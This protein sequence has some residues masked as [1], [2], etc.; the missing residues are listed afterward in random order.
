MK[1]KLT[2]LTFIIVILI[3][4]GCSNA[5]EPVSASNKISNIAQLP[6]GVSEWN[7]NGYPAGGMGVLGLFNL[8]VDSSQATAELSSLRTNEL[9]DV[10]ESVDITNFLM[11]APCTNCAKIKSVSLDVDGN[12]VVSIGI[13]HPFDV[14]EPLKPVSGRNRADRHVFNVEGIIVSNAP[15]TSFPLIGEAV[16]DFSLLNA[17]GYTDYLDPSLDEIYP[18]DATI[19]PYVLHFDDYSAGNFD[20][21]YP[22]GFQSVTDP[23]PSGNLVMAMGCDYNYQDYV[24]ALDGKMDFIYA[25]GCTYAVSAASKNDRFHPEY[26]I[27]QHNKKAASEVRFEIISND[28][29]GGDTSSS[30]QIEVH[31][32]DINHGVAVGDALNEMR[33]DSSVN[34]IF[35]DVPGIITSPVVIDGSTPISGTGHDPSDPLIYQGTI[36]N[37]NGAPEGEYPG[38]IKVTDNYAPG[39]NES[40]LLNTLDGI[41]RVAPTENP[42]AGLF[43]ID[44]FATYQTFSISVASGNEEPVAILLSDPDPAQISQFDTVDFDATTSYD[45][46]GSITEYAFD[47]DWTGYPDPLSFAPDE[48]NTTGLATSTPYANAGTFIAGLRVTD[49]LGAVGYDSVTVEVSEIQVIYVDDSN[50]SGTENGTMQYPYNTIQEGLNAASN[51]FEVWVDDSGVN[52]TGPVTLKSGVVLKSVN[53]NSGD[54]DDEACIAYE[55]T[56]AVVIGTDNATIQGFVIDG[57]RYGIDCDGSSPEIIDCRVVNLRYADCIGIWLRSG[58]H[59]HLDGIEVYDLNNNTDYGYATFYGIV[60]DNCPA[61]GANNVLIEHTIVHQVFSSDIIGLGG[62][63]CNPHGI[64]INNS[65]G[66]QVKNTI[67]HD[68]TGGNYNEVYG[69]RVLNS[70]DVD[71]VNNVI[72]DVDKT[73]YY[74]TAYGLYIVDCTTLDVRN[75]IISHVHKGEGGTGGY[76]QT[77]YGIYQS[78]ATYSFEYND[79]YDCQTELYLNLTPGIGCIN[80]DPLYENPGTNFHLASGSPCINTGDPDI[81]DP[82]SSRSDMGC[83]GGPG[84]NW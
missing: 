44:E 56:S 4:Q 82:D 84:G 40:P 2:F 62:G 1:N 64:Y 47:F 45:T 14:G 42:L 25:V 10:L 13:K 5:H 65:N 11:L 7:P 24:F 9:T 18:T 32:V 3:S 57:L 76:Y 68:I 12:L 26:R 59:A 15:S 77:A 79:V 22:M 37:T 60:V 31:V 35:I 48:T 33:S 30:A 41:K 52:Y 63:Y 54:G 39:Q 61:S 28:L 55:A 38:L 75:T 49:N 6:V 67:V 74:G 71:L 69:I 8:H 23:P 34:D 70:Q 58:S 72:Y 46:D 43:V 50:T 20:P 51:G 80:A 53:W 81:L 17:D 78:G 16:A 19:H 21:S 73:Y 66:T 27:P 36:V 29:K 83:Y